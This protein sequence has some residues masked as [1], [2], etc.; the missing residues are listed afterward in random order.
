MYKNILL[1]NPEIQVVNV[2]TE[3]SSSFECSVQLMEKTKAAIIA[4]RQCVKSINGL[5]LVQLSFFEWVC[6]LVAVQPTA[7]QFLGMGVSKAL[8]NALFLEQ[9]NLTIDGAQFHYYIESCI[10]SEF[11]GYIFQNGRPIL[12]LNIAN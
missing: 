12:N 7:V 6:D 9:I 10:Q 2:K 3:H 4:S 8:I 5:S 1:D 11:F